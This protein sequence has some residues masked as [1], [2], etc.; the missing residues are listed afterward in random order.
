MNFT[1]KFRLYM[2]HQKTELQYH[3]LGFLSGFLTRTLLGGLIEGP[4][5]SSLTQLNTRLR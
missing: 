1:E 2:R 3:I 4:E 5:E